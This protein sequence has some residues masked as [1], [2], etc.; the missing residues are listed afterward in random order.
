MN[1]IPTTTP[2]SNLVSHIRCPRHD[3]TPL[4]NRMP[5][6]VSPLHALAFFGPVAHAP[7]K[8]I[9]RLCGVL[10]FLPSGYKRGGVHTIRPYRHQHF[11]ATPE[12]FA[13][14]MLW[15]AAVFAWAAME[16]EGAK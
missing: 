16:S 12:L 13:D 14:V 3:W 5:L 6:S 2:D 1:T 10:G 15:N 8:R 9:C 11:M 4:Y 7:N